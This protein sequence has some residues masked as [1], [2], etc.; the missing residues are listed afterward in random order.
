MSNNLDLQKKIIAKTPFFYGWVMVFMA[1]LTM[2]FTGPGQTF[3]FSIFI[4]QFIREF[5]WTRAQ[6]NNY[7]SLATLVSGSTM[8][9]MGKYVDRYGTKKFMIIASVLLTGAMFLLSFVSG[10]L[11]VLFVG[12]FLGRFSGQGV[13]ALSS[14]VLTPHWFIKK[15]GLALML[16]GLGGSIGAATFPKLN[17]FLIDAYGWRTAFQIL[18]L[19]VFVI[20]VPLCIIYVVNKPEDV[21]KYPDDTGEKADDSKDLEIIMMDEKTSL[22]QSEVLRSSAFWIIF[23]A[24]AQL[25]MI[26]T[27]IALNMLSIFRMGGLT[28]DFATTIMSISPLLGLGSSVAVG[29]FIHKIK[30]PQYL[31]ALLCFMQA[32]GYFVLSGINSQLDAIV[33]MI[34]VGLAGGSFQLV[35]KILQPMFFGRRYLGGVV[36]LVTIAWVGGSALGP[37]VFGNAYEYFGGYEQILT[38]MAL[39]PIVAGV[40]LFFAEIPKKRRG[41]GLGE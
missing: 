34:L 15:R 37:T 11:V 32:A 6:V 28:E 25:S 40:A 14:G 16:A 5:G 1:A 33:Y 3:S 39:V 18:G 41:L 20:C 31:L 2:F 30:R 13:L 17:M 9:L 8:F 26:G 22:N 7:Y 36:G 23:I 10:N 19:G 38:I 27:G 4:D 12:F 29:L 24:A 35:H 21:G